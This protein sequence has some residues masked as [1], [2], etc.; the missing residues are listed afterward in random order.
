MLL[1]STGGLTRAG[2]QCLW[3][4]WKDLLQGLATGRSSDTPSRGR[5]SPIKLVGN[6]GL[7]QQIVNSTFRL[8]ALSVVFSALVRCAVADE[9]S[10]EDPLRV[11][12]FNVR[13]GTA[14]DGE[15][16]WPRRR[17][18]LVRTIRAFDPDILGL[19]EAMPLQ[20]ETLRKAFATHDYVGRSREKDN[21]NGE[22]CA[23]LVRRER[24]EIRRSGTFWLSAIPEEVGSK[25]WDAALPRISTWVDLIDHRAGDRAL[26]CYNAHFDHVGNQS[27]LESAKL[28]RAAG[29]N[30]SS[31]SHWSSSAIS[32]LPTTE[33]YTRLW[34][35]APTRLTD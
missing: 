28:L 20:I 21:P 13:F 27:R 5:R 31:I 25:S 16:S 8:L 10:P 4:K 18:F 9:L 29:S 19:Q 33:K 22:Q 1:Q 3:L 35:V 17:D 11:M 2:K 12:T 34:W 23:V 30:R 7:R 6:S 32:T 15:N 26:R 24:F 14:D